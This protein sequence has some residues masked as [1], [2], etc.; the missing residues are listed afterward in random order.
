MLTTFEI[1]LKFFGMLNFEMQNKID[2]YNIPVSFK[3]LF[4]TFEINFKI[5]GMLNI[6][7]H[8]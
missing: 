2:I 3:N 5:F 4:T 7:M 1:N 8:N 6:G